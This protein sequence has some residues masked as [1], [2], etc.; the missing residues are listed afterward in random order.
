MNNSVY[1]LIVSVLLEFS[2]ALHYCSCKLSLVSDLEAAFIHPF[3][4]KLG[5]EF[6][7]LS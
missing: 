3:K 1:A 7:K 5:L 4:K 2:V 6:T